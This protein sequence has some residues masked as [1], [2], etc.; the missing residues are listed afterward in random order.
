MALNNNNVADVPPVPPRWDMRFGE[1][2]STKILRR[3]P[4]TSVLECE[5]KVNYAHMGREVD[6]HGTQMFNTDWAPAG[7][8]QNILQKLKQ[9][10]HH[11][12]RWLLYGT[13]CQRTLGFVGGVRLEILRRK[14]LYGTNKAYI[15]FFF[16]HVVQCKDV[17]LNGEALYTIEH[18]EGD[19]D[20]VDIADLDGKDLGRKKNYRFVATETGMNYILQYRDLLS[21]VWIGPQFKEHWKDMIESWHERT[22]YTGNVF[23]LFVA[24]LDNTEMRNRMA[25][26]F[27]KNTRAQQMVILLY[28]KGGWVSEQDIENYWKTEQAEQDRV[29]IVDKD[30]PK[31]KARMRKGSSVATNLASSTEVVERKH[32]NVGAT[33]FRIRRRHWRVVPQP[34]PDN[35]PNPPPQ[36]AP[37]DDNLNAMINQQLQHLGQVHVQGLPANNAL[38]LDPN[39]GQQNGAGNAN[40]NINNGQNPGNENNNANNDGDQENPIDLSQSFDS[41]E[42]GQTV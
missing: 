23:N 19:P 11:Y 16:H 30:S 22:Q 1:R 25:T 18:P 39:V 12:F 5:R 41:S 3:R 38:L 31:K 2:K 34:F 27:C 6:G 24:P 40:N 26:Y 7:A 28:D 33:Y 14:C 36:A 32:N 17:N 8:D 35:P 4:E 20:A 9:Q 10:Q 37:Q 21:Q 15:S 42:G 13:I 29:N